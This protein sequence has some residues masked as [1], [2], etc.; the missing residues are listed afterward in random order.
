MYEH[1]ATKLCPHSCQSPAGAKAE[2]YRTQ[3]RALNLS[4]AK[5]KAS[6]RTSALL[7][8]FAMVAMVELQIDSDNPVPPFLLLIFTLC[9]VLLV[10]IHLL[11][12]MISTCILPYIDAVASNDEPTLEE[13]NESPHERMSVFIEISWTLSNVF[14]IFLFLAEVIVICWTRFWTVPNQNSGRVAAASATIVLIPVLIIFVAFAFHFYRKLT[15]HRVE[16]TVNHLKEVEILAS[17][18]N[19]QVDLS[20]STPTRISMHPTVS[21][22][23]FEKTTEF[24]RLRTYSSHPNIVVI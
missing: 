21:G 13:I 2:S 16:R 9:T 8:G 23:N 18:L 15:I 19:S 22:N 14:G 11:A 17:E 10:S 4:R 12:L 3:L 5:L 1:Q 20:V 24:G 7:A 6:S